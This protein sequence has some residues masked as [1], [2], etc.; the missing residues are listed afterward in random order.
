M[1][2]HFRVIG[3][4]GP[5]YARAP[6]TVQLRNLRSL[7]TDVAGLD[8]V[9]IPF[10]AVLHVPSICNLSLTTSKSGESLRSLW[11]F[12]GPWTS[13]ESLRFRSIFNG[14]LD[15]EDIV[16]IIQSL[17]HFLV[18]EVYAHTAAFTS[19]YFLEGFAQRSPC[20]T[21][22]LGAKLQTLFFRYS[23]GTKFDSFSRALQ[24]RCPPG[25]QFKLETVIILCEESNMAPILRTSKAS[26]WWDQ[27]QD[28]GIDVQLKSLESYVKWWE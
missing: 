5:P 24:S 19:A 6:G 23:A 8:W 22:V 20:G 12:L 15:G 9:P 21:P 17:E 14:K 16:H 3:Y 26:V 2:S 28:V 7:T 1:P 4:N 10:F 13:L 18:L 27:L 25:S 11:T